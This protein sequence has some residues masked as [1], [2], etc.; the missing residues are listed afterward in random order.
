MSASDKAGC[1]YVF[2]P[3]LRTRKKNWQVRSARQ[4]RSF[5]RKQRTIY[6][7][8]GMREYPTLKK[9]FRYWLILDVESEDHDNIEAN[10]EAAR[11]LF[12]SLEAR[13]LTDELQITLTG[14]GF[15]FSWPYY[16]EASAFRSFMAWAETYR[17]IDTGIYSGFVKVFS[18]ETYVLDVASDIFRMDEDAYR[19]AV[20][21][22]NDTAQID[23][24]ALPVRPLPAVWTN[25]LKE[26]ARTLQ[27]S[28]SIISLDYTAP[29]VRFILPVSYLHE[30]GISFQD[31]GGYW[32]LSCCPACG[33]PDASPYV[34]KTG[35]LKCFHQNSCPA[36][37]SG[38]LPPAEWLPDWHEIVEPT[39]LSAT[40]PTTLSNA[41][42]AIYNALRSQKNVL[43]GC[44]P[45]SGKTYHLIQY[46]AGLPDIKTVIAVDTKRLAKEI[47]KENLKAKILEGRST[48]NCVK[49][50]KAEHLARRGF[51]PSAILCPRCSEKENCPY[52]EQFK[53]LTP[54]VVCT[55]AMFNARTELQ[56]NFKVYVFDE[57][58]A[59]SFFFKI[60]C[61]TND[62][63]SLFEGLPSKHEVIAKKIN[64]CV[65]KAMEML[66]CTQGR[67]AV[68]MR[69]YTS[70]DLPKEVKN[71]ANLWQMAGVSEAEK[72]AALA[73]IS[74]AFGQRHFETYPQYQRRLEKRVKTFSSVRWMLAAFSNSN[75]AYIEIEERRAVRFVYFE[76]RKPNLPNDA[77]VIVL[78]GTHDQ[79]EAE[80]LFRRKLQVIEVG[81]E[82]PA[83][84]KIHLQIG[85]GKIKS[86]GKNK[87]WHKKTFQKACQHLPVNVRS[88][89]VLTHL[90][91]QDTVREIAMELLKDKKID[92][93]HFFANRGL[94]KW[95]DFD[96]VI[97]YGTPMAN[98]NSLL[99][100]SIALFPEDAEKRKTWRLEV[101]KKDLV[102][103][104][105]RIRPVNGNKTIIIVGNHWPQ[106]L[107]RP[108]YTVNLKRTHGKGQAMAGKHNKNFMEAVTRCSA[109]MELHG[110]ITKEIGW[111]LGIGTVNEKDRLFFYKQKAGGLSWLPEVTDKAP[112]ILHDRR[113]WLNVLEAVRQ[114][115]Q[116]APVLYASGRQYG[117]RKTK[118]LG[119]EKA[120]IQ[121]YKKHGF[122]Y[123]PQSWF[124]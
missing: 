114:K 31:M 8:P 123:E 78:D 70:A 80:E 99:D 17:S 90:K 32:K 27:F 20:K 71:C 75:Q 52:H 68:R 100:L 45:G 30:K 77:R 122:K 92:V 91:I 56:Q 63:N 124:W 54:C 39:T 43:I 101:G 16:F 104:V 110:F 107:G 18:P 25:I 9:P 1:F 84:Q 50:E 47:V 65:E 5:L 21:N 86:I 10:I 28:D 24:L 108:D 33:R 98:Q 120:V 38:G 34:T 66:A 53:K 76:L 55:H 22:L 94:N 35:W 117:H 95:S 14:R 119:T 81:V 102:Q 111:L 51:S 46:L 105:H 48:T 88:V 74:A 83:C 115:F 89:L 96:S 61:K 73:D 19:Y 11:N 3:A 12:S 49:Y 13:M 41:R 118:G 15:R 106:E 37:I 26:A 116:D 113:A 69:L 42:T 62:I 58:S 93:I 87:K 112:V 109:F 85:L 103:N 82:L 44:T 121:F 97:A 29:A 79:Q 57:S 40:L 64:S 6:L 59:K 72:Q 60:L 67:K 36:G 2:K 4:I 23:R 7:T